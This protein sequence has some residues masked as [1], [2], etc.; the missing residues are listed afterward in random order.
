MS[1]SQPTLPS[2]PDCFNEAP[3]YEELD[4]VRPGY[5]IPEIG[6]E[7]NSFQSKPA[8]PPD[9]VCKGRVAATV[10]PTSSVGYSSVTKGETLESM[11][12]WNQEREKQIYEPIEIK[13]VDDYMDMS[14]NG[15]F[16]TISIDGM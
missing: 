15:K 1:Q 12:V 14:L 2:K 13:D 6:T 10:A 4:T 3:L 7:L 11:Q 5:P 9:R 16:V 8:L